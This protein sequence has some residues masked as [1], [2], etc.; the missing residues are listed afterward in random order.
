RSS[1]GEEV[2]LSIVRGGAVSPTALAERIVDR[3]C[4]V[5]KIV[6]AAFE[7]ELLTVVKRKIEEESQR[8][9]REL[10]GR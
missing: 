5:V 7:Q 3:L 1:V 10:G 8:L 6:P 2:V 9:I 4:N